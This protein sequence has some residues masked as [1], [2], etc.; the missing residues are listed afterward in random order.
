[1]KSVY[2]ASHSVEA[3]MILHLL[4]QGGLKAVVQGEYLQGAIGELPVTGLVKVMVN[5]EDYEEAREIIELWESG[6]IESGPED[7]A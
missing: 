4:E 2:E 7:T 3:H 6:E 1:M 5:A